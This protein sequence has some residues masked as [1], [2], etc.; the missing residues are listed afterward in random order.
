VTGAFAVLGLAGHAGV[1]LGAR[2]GALPG[3]VPVDPSPPEAH[4][5]IVEELS[6]PAY[7][8]AQPTL[9]D[10]I[11]KAISDW[12]SSLTLGDAQGPPG[13]GL[14]VVVVLVAAAIVVAILIFGLPRLN[15]RSAVAGSLFGDDDARDAA[16][17]RRDAAAA[18]ARG[19]HTT[20]V[21]E[22]FR[23]IA[24][25]LAERLL[26]TVTP[27]TTAS[28]FAARAGDAFPAERAPLTAAA[29]VF[30][31]V[32]YLG[33]EGTADQYRDLVALDES[34]RAAKPRLEGV[35]A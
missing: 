35:P 33:R 17:M 19:D 4:D 3:A 21:A 13:L 24:R 12:L 16:A 32:R 6:K 8:A 31:G 27:G 26:V 30:D 28:G 22:Q 29:A 9:Y 11:S 15:R 20:A 14:G 18:A 23:A 25:G 34:L 7:Q 1:L 5:W 2:A 10:R